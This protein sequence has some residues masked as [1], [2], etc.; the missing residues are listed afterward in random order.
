MSA[1][2]APISVVTVVREN[3]DQDHLS[4]QAYV[5]AHRRLVQYSAHALRRAAQRHVAPD[6]VDYVVAHGTCCHRTGIMFFFL[7]RRD[8]PPEDAGL[9]WAQ[10]LVGTV[11]LAS[12]DGEVIT[13]YRNTRALR[14][15][16]RKTKYRL[17]S[18]ENT[19]VAVA[20][21]GAGW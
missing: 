3:V 18:R 15:I 5:S 16:L 14:T 21:T 7:R 6:A 17:A 13:T 11:V 20:G 10:R 4:S 19:L 1:V 9:E 8:V 12:R 2:F